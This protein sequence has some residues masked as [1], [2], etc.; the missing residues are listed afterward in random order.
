MAIGSKG[1]SRAAILLYLLVGIV[2]F[3]VV[4]KT[5]PVYMDYYAMEDEV[6]QQLQLSSINADDVIL[7]DLTQKV[8]ELELPVKP[9]DIRIF[10]HPGGLSISVG[11]VSEVDYGYGFKRDFPFQIE[12]DTS[13]LKK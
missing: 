8:N 10:R 3:Y 12:G 13:R 1:G 7:D 9:N 6:T 2:A 11:W 4:V 5:I